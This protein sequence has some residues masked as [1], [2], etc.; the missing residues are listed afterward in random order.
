MVV[1][2]YRSRK[3]YANKSRLTGIEEVEVKINAIWLFKTNGPVQR[4]NAKDAIIN[5]DRTPSYCG[6]ITEK[7]SSLCESSMS[8]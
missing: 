6:R 8:S 4:I 7:V 1:H 3:L 2:H 5:A